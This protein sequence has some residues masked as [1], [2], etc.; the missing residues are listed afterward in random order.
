MNWYFLIPGKSAP[1]S[2][3]FF[4]SLPGAHGPLFILPVGHSRNHLLEAP[5]RRL[6]IGS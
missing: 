4:Y 3:P 2:C 1:R 5:Q 6:D